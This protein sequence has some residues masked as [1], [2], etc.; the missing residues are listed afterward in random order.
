MEIT[1]VLID[2]TFDLFNIGHMRMLEKLKSDGSKFIIL[3]VY[4]DD[5]VKEKGILT[6]M[7]GYER[8]ENV[9]HCRYVDE[10]IYPCPYI[11]TSE[12]L[13]S[14]NIQVVCNQSWNEKY[15]LI[16]EFL[17]IVPHEEGASDKEIISRV[18]TEFDEYTERTLSRGYSYN[19]TGLTQTEA[20]SLMLR[21]GYRKIRK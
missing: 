16:P 18:L 12:F 9:K 7:T 13:E 4:D 5:T 3:G 2:G 10:V 19:D 21:L 8:S 11:L 14:H 6:I 17:L 1:R 15:S 20:I